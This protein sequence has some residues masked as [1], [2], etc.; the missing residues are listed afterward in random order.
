MTTV[1]Q[2]SRIDLADLN[3]L[4]FPKRDPWTLTDSFVNKD[5]H[6][7]AE[8]PVNV[9]PPQCPAL[10]VKRKPDAVFLT[11]EFAVPAG[12]DRKHLHDPA[13]TPIRNR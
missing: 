3:G 7:T 12:D 1:R 5:G 2:M 10:V 4:K 11:F 8:F 9:V 6:R 13:V